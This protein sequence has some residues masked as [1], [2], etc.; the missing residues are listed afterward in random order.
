MSINIE[1]P[2]DVLTDF[3][4]DLIDSSTE[5]VESRVE[6]LEF[7]IVDENDIDHKIECAIDDIDLPDTDDFVE[8]FELTE[9]R[10]EIEG[11]RSEL[12][13][14]YAFAH[15]AYEEIAARTLS[16]RWQRLKTTLRRWSTNGSHAA[17][18]MAKRIGGI[19]R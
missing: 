17:R 18:S 19:V 13:E 5:D 8:Q 2:T 11:L 1:I 6:D 15:A 7:Q 4:Q 14:A 3:V 10:E 16:V 9:L 12:E